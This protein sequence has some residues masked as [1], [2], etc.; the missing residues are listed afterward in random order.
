[1]DPPADNKEQYNTREKQLNLTMLLKR[2]NPQP[3]SSKCYTHVKVALHSQ[4]NWAILLCDVISDGK[5]E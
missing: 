1:M 2:Y 5:T 4:F 3:Q